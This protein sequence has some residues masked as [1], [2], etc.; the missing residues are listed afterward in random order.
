[1]T[2]TYTKGMEAKIPGGLKMVQYTV[3]ATDEKSITI[4]AKSLG[5]STIMSAFANNRSL[6]SAVIRAYFVAIGTYTA[7]KG[8][9][10][11]ATVRAYNAKEDGDSGTMLAGTFEILAVGL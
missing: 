10:N 11:Y 2:V 3:G 1:M 6:D 7:G 4:A 5:L 8:D 9:A